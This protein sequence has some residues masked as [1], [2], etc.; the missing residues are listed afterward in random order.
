MQRVSP[1]AV[2]PGQTTTVHLRGERLA[3]ATV[4]WTS[5]PAQTKQIS[6][7][8][9]E[10]VFSFQLPPEVQPG[11][12]FARLA[13]SNGVS[14]LVPLVIDDLPSLAAS[15]TNTAP[16]NAQALMLPV[17]VDGIASA[18]RS[19]YFHF[20]G[21]KG[22]RLAIDLL[23][24]RL[25]SPLNP[26]VRLL[27]PQGH[28][29]AYVNDDPG[30]GP[31]VRFAVKL[32]GTGGYLLEVRDVNFQ[33]GG[34]FRYRL[35]LGDFPVATGLFPAA[36]QPG[37][38]TRLTA[39]GRDVEKVSPF[40]MTVP[41]ETR[42]ATRGVRYPGGVASGFVSVV[43]SDLPQMFERE[44]NDRATNATPFTVPAALNGRFDRARD[45]DYYSFDV[46]K[47]QRLLFTARTR[48]LAL[49]CDVLLR[50]EKPDGSK[51]VESKITEADDG[52][53]TNTFKEA[54]NY[55]LRVEELNRRGGPDLGYRVEVT[56]V[57]PGFEIELDVDKVEAA[58]GGAFELKFGLRR[59]EFKG[60]IKLSF[61]GLPEDCVIKGDKVAEDQNTATARI[62][63]P[64]KLPP[65]QLIPFRVLAVATVNDRDVTNRVS[66]LPALRK[67]WPRDRHLPLELDGQLV[68]GV[69]AK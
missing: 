68:L 30:V 20:R 1:G 12:G 2:M 25:A 63:L 15:G 31:D 51:V 8:A 6:A 54:G 56:P 45:V 17:A 50:V 69:R 62:T 58:P 22:Q 7:G 18:D 5:F 59:R 65:A 33:G 29:A 46:V 9:G 41:A 36:V 39:L 43:A 24:A 37:R 42:R 19:D 26:Q 21:T 61:P 4:V 49:P 66:T 23:A 57:E 64:A 32:P 35:R 3:A 38:P 34:N 48:S 10:A 40:T 28:E 27:D 13:G 53:I 47:D 11:I 44:P 52:L 55:R 60:A 14:E 16:T 67:L